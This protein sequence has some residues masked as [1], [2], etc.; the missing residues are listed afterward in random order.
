MS[1]ESSHAGVIRSVYRYNTICAIWSRS[2]ELRILNECLLSS[3]LVAVDVFPGLRCAVD[4]GIRADTDDLAILIVE[5]LDPGVLLAIDLVDE[6]WDEGDSGKFWS[7]VAA[8][9]VDAE[10]I[11][12]VAE[13]VYEELS[14]I[15]VHQ[16]GQ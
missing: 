7:G 12:S 11:K 4:E 10:G 6:L 3:F 8:Q 14:I 15:N 13:V 2:V 9:R 16:H 1:H 5:C